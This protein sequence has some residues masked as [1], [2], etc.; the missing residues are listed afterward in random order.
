MT[1]RHVVED[2]WRGD[3]AVRTLVKEAFPGNLPPA[4]ASATL[5][6]PYWPFCLE[7]ASGSFTPH[8]LDDWTS[9]APG[10]VGQPD[11]TFSPRSLS[12]PLL[13]PFFSLVCIP[14][15]CLPSGSD[16]KESACSAG[17]LGLI[18]GSGRSP[19]GGHVN[20]LQ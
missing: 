17:E 15:I 13:L 6:L 4:P 9:V 1:P 18:P 20:P 12:L 5:S 8:T 11:S 2:D 10:Q 16:G 7:G 14:L 19:G 3:G